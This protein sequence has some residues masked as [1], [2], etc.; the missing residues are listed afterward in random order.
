MTFTLTD[1][2]GTQGFPGTVQATVRHTLKNKGIWNIQLN[3]TATKRTP[4]MRSGHHYWNLEAY[5]E[6][7]DLSAHF[8]ELKASRIVATDGNLIPNGN[9]TNITGTPADFSV[10]KSIGAAI[11]ATT[12]SEFCGTGE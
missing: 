10:A 3:A 8:V 5:K 9:I 6:T 12:P 11:N 7:Q 1:P 4:I 2:D